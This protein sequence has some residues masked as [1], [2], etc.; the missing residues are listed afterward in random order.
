MDRGL[1]LLMLM[2]LSVAPFYSQ[3]QSSHSKTAELLKPVSLM[4]FELSN[5]TPHPTDKVTIFAHLES[6][7][8]S[9]D[10]VRVLVFANFDGASVPMLHLAPGLWTLSLD[11]GLESG[12]HQL[13]TDIYLEDRSETDQFRA[14]ISLLNQQIAELDARIP[15]EEDPAQRAILQADRD[16][17]DNRRN[18]LRSELEAAKTGLGSEDFKFTV[19]E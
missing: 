10:S 8:D 1:S 5:S 9:A 11:S 12:E 15:A 3:A 4:S 16:E 6:D 17:K 13:H 2:A 14:E 18:F 19:V 7:Y